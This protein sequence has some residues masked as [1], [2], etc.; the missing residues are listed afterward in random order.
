MPEFYFDCARFHFFK[1]NRS[2]GKATVVCLLSASVSGLPSSWSDK[3]AALMN[4][5]FAELLQ[6][7]ENYE[8]EYLVVGGTQ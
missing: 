8:V 4:S 7:F 3:E 2:A 1:T 6:A 5:D